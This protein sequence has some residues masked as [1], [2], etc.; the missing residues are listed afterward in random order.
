M[1]W[2]GAMVRAVTQW[3]GG[4]PPVGQPAARGA[5]PRRPERAGSPPSP[6]VNSLVAQLRG[7]APA[8]TPGAFVNCN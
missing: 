5:P 2:H 3:S 7:F 8:N 4:V 6:L 1:H